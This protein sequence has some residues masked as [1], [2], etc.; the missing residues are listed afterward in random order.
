MGRRSPLGIEGTS[1][2]YIDRDD[3]GRPTVALVKARD[4]IGQYQGKRFTITSWS[5]TGAPVLPEEAISWAR[6]TRKSFVREEAV[7]RAGTFQEFAALLVAN[8]EASGVSEG[9]LELIGAV[10]EGLA[11]AGISDMR[12]DAFPVRVRKWITGLETGWS[13]PA[14]ATNRRT[15]CTPLSPATRN[16]LLTICRQVTGLAL[17]KR[18]IP[19]DPLGEL[20]RFK[21]PT[22]VKS[23]FTIEELRT[24]VG[25]ESRDHAIRRRA[26]L[27]AEVDALGKPRESAVKTVAKRRKVHSTTI[28]NAF[29]RP[30][31]PDPWWLA[32]CILTY[33]GCRADEGMHLQWPWIKWDA[34]VIH[35]KLTDDYDSKGDAERLIPL[36][37]ELKAILLPFAKPAGH[38]LP[39]EI[40]AGG[41]GM[42]KQAASSEGK[43]AGDYTAA[44]RRYLAR[45]G[46]DPKDRTAHSLRHTFISI[47]L[48]RA[49]TNVERL[50]KAVGHA[51]FSTTMGYG[52]TS[53]LYESEVDRWPDGRFWLRRET[54]ASSK[55]ERSRNE[56]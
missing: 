36:E 24:M 48:A 33:T 21:E 43:G 20:Q 22:F 32:C 2:S 6:D 17:V 5:R 3:R 51:D 46:V 41:S 13:L 28:Y 11:A 23:T 4:E 19:F 8:L 50:R 56:K 55:P 39:P 34:D 1:V 25:D 7:A 52:T 14:N 42:R 27:Q 18:R 31:G 9:R 44:L 15:I 38:I 35:L 10:A 54:I 29:A 45:I 49:D 37:P 16:K 53:Q 40:R 30:I 47:K 26:E 12:S